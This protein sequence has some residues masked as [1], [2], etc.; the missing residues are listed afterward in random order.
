MLSPR[1]F[2]DIARM[3]P[4]GGPSPGNPLWEQNLLVWW[5]GLGLLGL[6]ADISDRV[7]LVKIIEEAIEKPPFRLVAKS[8]WNSSESVV[9][10]SIFMC[11]LYRKISSCMLGVGIPVCNSRAWLAKAADCCGDIPP[12]IEEV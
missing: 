11:C 4:L 7:A 10:S 3:S 6:E 9:G 2:A 8:L 5:F 12:S 1:T